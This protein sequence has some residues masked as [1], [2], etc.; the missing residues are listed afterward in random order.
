MTEAHRRRFDMKMIPLTQGKF[1]TVDDD[2]YVR[3]AVRKWQ[4]RFDG[5]NW[6][7]CTRIG[8]KQVQMHRVI[9]GVTDPKIQ[10]DHKDGD[11]LH[12][13]R[14]NLRECTHT[15]NLCNRKLFKNN[16]SGFRGVYLH[17]GDKRIAK[18]KV[19]GTLHYL[20]VFPNAEAAARA[21]DKAAREHHGPFARLN[22][23]D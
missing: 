11:G 21:Y 14:G 6:Y 23:P 3:L 1:T 9:M 20:G 8:F 10:V 15:Q 13:W 12:N 7:A 2:D 17:T 18:I 19:G 4:A 16:T 22:F 5:N